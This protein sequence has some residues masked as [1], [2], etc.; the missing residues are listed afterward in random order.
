MTSDPQDGRPGTQPGNAAACFTFQPGIAAMYART[1]ASPSALG[2]ARV[3]AR[4][5]VDGDL[6]W[7]HGS[8]SDVL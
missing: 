3:A 2:D 1:G 6:F 8:F 5:E 4:E 7:R